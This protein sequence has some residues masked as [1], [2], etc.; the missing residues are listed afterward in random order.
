[1]W[2]DEANTVTQKTLG[3]G[4]DFYMYGDM[5]EGLER[6]KDSTDIRFWIVLSRCPTTSRDQ[7]KLSIFSHDW[8]MLRV[9]I[10]RTGPPKLKNAVR[11]WRGPVIQSV[12]S[13]SNR[14][15]HHSGTC[16]GSKIDHFWSISLHVSSERL[17]VTDVVQ[18]VGSSGLACC[19]QGMSRTSS[20]NPESIRAKLDVVLSGRSCEG[21][22]NLDYML[23]LLSSV[24]SS[25]VLEF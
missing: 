2:C 5:N 18:V 16:R 22:Q 14:A 1:M 3:D 10:D 6:G 23:L 8:L 21:F 24:F 11:I 12:W 13:N 9:I 25:L 15:R 19:L 7:S 17:I 20:P 4:M